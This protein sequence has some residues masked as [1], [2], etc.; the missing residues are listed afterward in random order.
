MDGISCALWADVGKEGIEAWYL[1][2]GHNI[3]HINLA[4]VVINVLGVRSARAIHSSYDDAVEA[5]DAR[6][7]WR[8]DDAPA[9]IIDVAVASL[10]VALG[11]P[12]AGT[13][14]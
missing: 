2:R 13:R 7:E 5:L 10:T 4:T 6:R 9:F 8:V 3:Q 11:A 14:A 1:Y 12:S